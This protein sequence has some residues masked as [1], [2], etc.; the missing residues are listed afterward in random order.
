MV[1]LLHYASGVLPR[2]SELDSHSRPRLVL[3]LSH[4][5]LQTHFASSLR[6]LTL[7]C[8]L[9]KHLLVSSTIGTLD[10]LYLTSRC[11]T[12]M[13]GV[14]MEAVCIPE[15]V[16]TFSSSAKDFLSFCVSFTFVDMNLRI[17]YCVMTDTTIGRWVSSSRSTKGIR[18]ARDDSMRVRAS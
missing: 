18:R 11:I 7:I 12:S 6:T 17:R 14:S 2:Q 16:P 9:D 13:T 5:Q 4:Q 15:Y 3:W 10:M 8:N 1:K